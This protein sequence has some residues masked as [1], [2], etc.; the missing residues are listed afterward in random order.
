MRDCYLRQEIVVVVPH[1]C[2][3]LCAESCPRC[4]E[5]WDMAL[6]LEARRI[7]GFQGWRAELPGN[8]W[9]GDN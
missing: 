8:F 5:A 7:C 4:D 9:I 1:P 2:D 6:L 3:S